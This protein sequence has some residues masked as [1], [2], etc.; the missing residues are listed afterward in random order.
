MGQK[1]K[2]VSLALIMLLSTLT[3]IMMAAPA[4]ATQVVI[5][6]A[7]QVVDGGGSS[8]R[9]AA[10]A[11][12]SEGNVHVVWSRSNQHLFYSM[13]S[14][15]GETLIDATQVSNSGLHKIYHPD[16]V[17][18]DN[19]NVHIVWADHSGQHK[20]MYTA[21]KPFATA[22]DGSNSND[23]ELTAIDDYIVAQQINNRDWPAIDVDSQGNVHIVWQDNYDE[24]DMFFQQPQI[25]YKMLQPDYTIQNAVVL[26]DD[27]LL[28]PIIGHKG[29]PDIV[30]DANDM[31][32][33]AW[34]DTRGG[35]V[36]L[37]FVVDTSG[38]MY[39]E[40][41]DVCT[42]IYGGNF[43]S[44]GYFKGIKP[45][46]EEGNMT[47]FETIYGLG[48]F[49]PSA[50]SSGNCAIPYQTGGSGQGPRA[51]PLGQVPGDDSGGVRKLPGTVY[52]GGTYSGYSG[53]DWGPGSNWA[54]LSWKDANGNVP[55]NPPTADDHRWNPNAT[56]IVL[57]VSDEGPKDGDPATGADDTASCLLYTSP[58]PRDS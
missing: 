4:A 15:R 42:V 13:V 33:I 50:A 51:T 47:V 37:V 46:L 57:P 24:L 41:A 6:E 22:M 2:S 55:G 8:D 35:K 31:V 40:W 48:N 30:I 38:S 7:I 5:T 39:S 45:M 34:D 3:G 12:D 28:T 16:M 53:E 25:Y 21:L 43:A 32:Q 26:F 1:E 52:N 9:M 36:E 14:P 11:A 49:L 44:G 19:D 17:I 27:T 58:S 23:G 20:I 18:D 29:H 56:K 54:C 10:V